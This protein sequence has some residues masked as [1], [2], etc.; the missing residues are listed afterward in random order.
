M[1]RSCKK[2][3]CLCHSSDYL[4]SFHHEFKENN[5]GFVFRSHARP[6]RP[7]SAGENQNQRGRE[8]ETGTSGSTSACIH[9]N[10]PYILFFFS[11][12]ILTAA[13]SFYPFLSCNYS[14]LHFLL[15]SHCFHGLLPMFRRLSLTVGSS[16]D[17]QQW[18]ND[19]RERWDMCLEMLR[20]ENSSSKIEDMALSSLTQYPTAL[21]RSNSSPVDAV[22]EAPRGK[23]SLEIMVGI[24]MFKLFHLATQIHYSS[25]VV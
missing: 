21:L 17:C 6:L 13:M 23:A 9:T 4:P 25:L 12:Q 18:R 10:P 15:I 8:N 24:E 1:G 14:S 11:L 3:L 2:P 5:H 22:N 19:K 20:F 16:C 7:K